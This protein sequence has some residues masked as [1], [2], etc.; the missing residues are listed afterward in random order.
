LGSP[1]D[2][3][4]GPLQFLK[5]KK[6]VAMGLI[7]LVWDARR[8]FRLAVLALGPAVLAPDPQ[9]GTMGR[10]S[11]SVVLLLVCFV[12]SEC[13]YLVF[14]LLLCLV[15]VVLRRF[16]LDRLLVDRDSILDQFGVSLGAN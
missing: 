12:V 10:G 9:R 8:R 1:D 11:R 14:R 7:P 13:V 4:L 16:V 3:N 5:N 2:H 15:V 6:S